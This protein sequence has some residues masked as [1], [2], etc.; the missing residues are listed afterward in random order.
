VPNNPN[1]AISA[2]RAFTG[3]AITPLLLL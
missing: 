3:L 1:V 2:A